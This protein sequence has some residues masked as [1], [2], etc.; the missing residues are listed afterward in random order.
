LLTTLAAQ[1]KT[2]SKLTRLAIGATVD[3]QKKSALVGR[4]FS[5]QLKSI[6]Y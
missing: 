2:N 3:A 4:K 1:P 6:P 5:S